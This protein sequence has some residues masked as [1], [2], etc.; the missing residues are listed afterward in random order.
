MTEVRDL[1]F[2]QAPPMPANV[3]LGE[4]SYL[5][6][7][8]Q[9]FERFFSRREPGLDLGRGVRVYTWTS[10]SVEPDGVV[11]V[12]DGAIL[13]GAAFMCAERISVGARV[14]LSYGTTVTDC[15]FHPHDPAERRADAIANAPHGDRSLRPRLVARPTVIED[16]AWVGIGA[17]ILKGVTVGTG[18]RVEPGAVVTADVPAGATASG[19]PARVG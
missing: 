3:R 10:F 6:R 5:E 16:D 19:N 1:S 2:G 7:H 11:E 14:V 4:G 15:D 8:R 12:G 9:T 17:M 18:A 13:V